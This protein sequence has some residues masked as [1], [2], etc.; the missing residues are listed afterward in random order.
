MQKLFSEYALKGVVIKNRVV[1]PP[2]VCPGWADDS[3]FVTN[4][5]IMH[6]EA[7]A[8]GGVGTIIIE[9]HSVNKDARMFNSQLG[10]WSDKHIE[11][12]SQIVKKCKK[13]GSTVLVQLYH[14][15]LKTP[16]NISDKRISPMDIFIGEHFKDTLSVEEIHN[17]QQEFVNA[18]IRAKNAGLDGI[19]LHGAHGYLL[20]QFSSYSVNT[21]NDEYGGNVSN[22]LRFA[23][24]IIRQ[25]KL[26]LGDNFIISYRMGGNDPTLSDSIDIAKELVKYGVD[27]IHVSTSGFSEIYPSVPDNYN[28]NWIVYA[29]TEIKKYINI[30]VIVGNGIKTPERAAYLVDN[31][32]A[33]FVAIG[34]DLITDPDWTD[35]AKEGL[36][37]DFC[38]DCH[39]KCK[40]YVCAELCPKYK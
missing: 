15:G 4:K 12:L 40:R 6:Y 22:R 7:R 2:M 36:K 13:H 31:G 17:L 26:T 3:G 11:G 38:L 37:I 32:L 18:A 1:M 29:G 23:G 35:K 25:I 5:N 33:E 21:R 19:E 8:K 28:Y 27:L 24:E 16:K 9:A 10:I 20:N 39:P 30:P 14:A 34:K